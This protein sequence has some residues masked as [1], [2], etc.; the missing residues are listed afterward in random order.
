MRLETSGV[1]NDDGGSELIFGLAV[2]TIEPVT[3]T[4]R[5]LSCRL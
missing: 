1:P 2:G 5:K 4:P 3:K